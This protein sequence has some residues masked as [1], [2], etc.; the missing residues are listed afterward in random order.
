[1]VV[2]I[3][4][5]TENVPMKTVGV[6][7]VTYQAEKWISACLAPI[8][9]S[10]LHP[11]VL[12]IDS[13]ST[14]RTVQAVRQM[15]VEAVVI[16]KSEFN[17]G[18]T[19]EMARKR[20]NTDIAVFLTQDAQLVDAQ[21]LAALIDPIVNGQ[22]SVTYARQLP[23]EG[24]GFF[25]AFL[26]EF[27]YPQDSHFRS[28]KDVEK[29]GVYTCFC[30]D[31]CAAYDN[32]ALDGIGGFPEVAFGEDA[33]AAAKLILAGRTIGYVAEA[34]VRHSHSYS[35]REE[36]CR[37][38]DIGVYRKKYAGLFLPFG[39]DKERGKAYAKAMIKRLWREKP[40]LIPYALV[41]IL[42]KGLGYYLGRSRFLLSDQ[43][44][45]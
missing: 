5:L 36:F 22:A 13:S 31:S 38:L 19:R 20:L 27:N 3:P 23:H 39:K 35:L 11:R 7:I 45:R 32:A 6:A 17:H 30:S 29:Y 18:L 4:P 43:V 15:G 25:E 8:L 28:L 1:M 40:W 33:V 41:Q 9:Q 42:M 24:A 26:R 37:H 44:Q 16:P 12:V 21:S 14:D 2:I 34:R 10:P